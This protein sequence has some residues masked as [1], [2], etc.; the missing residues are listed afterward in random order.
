MESM[1]KNNERDEAKSSEDD[2]F[3]AIFCSHIGAP[4]IHDGQTLPTIASSVA[5]LK[6]N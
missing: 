1:T 3:V 5:L 2:K 4:L 6:E